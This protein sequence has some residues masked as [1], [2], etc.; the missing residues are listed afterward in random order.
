MTRD[1]PRRRLS[2]LGRCY[3]SLALVA[4]NTLVLLAVLNAGAALV[5]AVHQR[6]LEPPPGSLRYGLERLSRVYPGMGDGEI[7]DLLTETWQREYVYAPLVQ[8]RERATA[9]RYVNI[10]TA[11]FRHSGDQGPWPPEQGDFV[12]FVYGGS[13]TF[14]YGVADEQTIPSR[15]QDLLAERG[16]G[17]TA[18]YNF[19]RGNYYSE[20]ERVLFEGHLAEGLRP[21]LA[22]FIDGLNEWKKAPKFTRRLE[23]LMRRPPLYPTLNALKSLPIVDLAR[24]ARRGSRDDADATAAAPGFAEAVLERWL[25]N[26][27][28]TAAIAREFDVDAVF[29][30]QP[31]P[32][33]E[34]EMEMHPFAGETRELFEQP[35]RRAARRAYE[36]MDGMRSSTP[37]LEPAG[38]FLWLADMQRGRTD[39]LY[40]D[41]VHYSAAFSRDIAAR[42]AEFVKARA[43]CDQRDPAAF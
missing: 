28:M 42:I 10:D 41:T 25:R 33:Y 3:S 39:P 36:L 7:E 16:C 4:L 2:R 20:Q 40:V 27:R 8:H 34:F 14:G 29:A 32:T 43:H 30:W 21:D 18:V 17:N 6:F 26:K 38:D 24:L 1:Q 23:L 13:T 37:A 5:L 31:L 9:G 22:I 15:L 12:V 19:G 35:N 11:G